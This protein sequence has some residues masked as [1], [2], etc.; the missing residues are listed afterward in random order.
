VVAIE[1]R[2]A[3]PLNKIKVPVRQL[4]LQKRPR[5]DDNYKYNIPANVMMVIGMMATSK[6]IVVVTNFYD[7]ITLVSQVSK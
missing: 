6:P 3:W 1:T 2:N 5:Q 4:S 7:D